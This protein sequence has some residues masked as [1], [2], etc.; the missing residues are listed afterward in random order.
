MSRSKR[1]ALKRAFF[2]SEVPQKD[3]A[4]RVGISESYLSKIVNGLHCAPALQEAVATEI[5]ELDSR[6]DWS[7]EDLFPQEVAAA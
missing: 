7:V 5:S 4:D 1:T 3:V 2:E 6:R